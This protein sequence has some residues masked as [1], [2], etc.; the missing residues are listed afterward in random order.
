MQFKQ[1]DGTAVDLKMYGSEYYMRA[2]GM[3]GFTVIRDQSTKNICY[4][5]LSE[6]GSKL[7]STGIL[8][9]GNRLSTTTPAA[10]VGFQKHLEINL[11]ARQEQIKANQKALS[12]NS[13]SKKRTQNNG[14]NQALN[15]PINPVSGN[16][17]GLCIVVDFSD[18][19]GVL[20]M[21]EFDDFCN[22]LNYSNN[23]NNG[24]LRKFYSDISGGLLDYE[25]VVYGY[26]RAPLTFQ[27]YDAMPYAVG[28]QQILGLALQ[29]IDAQGFDFSTLSLNPDNSIQAINLM[30]TGNPPNWAQGMWHH[31]GNYTGFS[32]D[33]VT[34]DD[35]NCS[36]ANDPLHLAVVAHENGHM[37]GKWPDTYKYDNT[38]GPDG[39]G[40]FDLMCWYGDYFN[41]TVPNP[42]FLANCGW[43]RM[44]DVTNYN[45][46]NTD[47]ANSLT[48]YRYLNINDTNE[49]FL[50]ENRL[51]TGRSTFIDDEGLTIWHIDRSGDNQSL[52]HEVYL[53]HANDDIY[54]HTGACFKAGFNEEYSEYTIP[55]SNY[56]NGDASGL[57]VWDIGNTAQLMNY[58]LGTGVASAS[59][60]II[61]QN[62]TNDNNSNGYLEA[63]E[64]GDLNLDAMNNGQLTSANATFTCT[65]S[66]PNAGSI[67]INTPSLN[68]GTINV[69]QTIPSVF[70]VTIAPGT[71]LG[72]DI[73]L[74]FL[75]TDGIDSIHI[76]RTLVVGVIEIMN[77]QTATTCNAIFFDAGGQNNYS[78]NTDFTKTFLPVSAGQNVEANFSF[79][80][81][82]DEINCNYDYLRIYNGPTALGQV[83][84][85][86]CGTNSPGT[87]TSTHASGALTF[88]FHS[89]GG[90]TGGGWQAQISCSGTN[91][92]SSI[93]EQEIFSIYP[94]PTNGIITV[95]PRIA[96]Q[97]KITVTNAIG[98]IITTKVLNANENGTLDISQQAPGI[99]F[100]KGE[101]SKGVTEKR[102]VLQ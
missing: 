70:N 9:Q 81:L 69:S 36:P 32:A 102:V 50:L 27:D 13:D 94:N 78:D 59:L 39:I 66:G 45:G 88:V 11:K 28:A 42:L 89:D 48:C 67:T 60:N 68:L 91:G 80:D 5:K 82:E 14:G 63:G 16:I 35:Y 64:T 10:I 30:Y 101:S 20:P 19:P 22:D 52:H 93:N 31:K 29:W 100:I 56:Y 90:V 61:Y 54:D 18:E 4:A 6:D 41:P 96:D 74:D 73:N 17:R 33:G 43:K 44:V 53:V 87:V 75:L 84:G 2:E 62:I 85:T 34:S 8:Y 65:A 58:K 37:I 24:S 77:N 76:S 1:A 47:T 7:I 26:F 15:T 79:F 23:G 46:V 12:G 57:K 51:K 97:L 49:F 99:Y 83:L 25:N 21:S 3:D 38:T 86:Y 71:P 98:Q 92:I 72:T 55:N 40:S 95:N